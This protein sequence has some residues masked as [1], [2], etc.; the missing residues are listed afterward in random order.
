MTQRIAAATV[1]RGQGECQAFIDGVVNAELK[2]QQE[3]LKAE[4]ERAHMI[5]ANRN[6]LLTD[7]LEA[8][9]PQRK[10]LL[11]RLRSAIE[12]AWAMLWAIT[13]GKCWVEMGETA[14][15][16]VDLRKEAEEDE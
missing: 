1:I 10:N 15:L 4:R 14:G 6:R 7:R 16:W 8:I 12:T 9:K 3:G 2:R 13:A 11:K 5:E